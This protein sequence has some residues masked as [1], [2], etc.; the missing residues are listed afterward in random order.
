MKVL[1]DVAEVVSI[2]R[3]KLDTQE[4]RPWSC[5]VMTYKKTLQKLSVTRSGFAARSP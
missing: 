2:L 4:R 5:I 3:T 1:I